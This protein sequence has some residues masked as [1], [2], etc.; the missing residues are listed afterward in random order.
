M[1]HPF[2]ISSV[3]LP[4]VACLL[5]APPPSHFAPLCQAE[6][7]A[8][9]ARHARKVAKK[10]AK[11]PDGTYLRFVFRD[12]SET[13]GTVDALKA[14]TFTLINADTNA[15]E[16]YRYVDVARVKKGRTYVG[17]GSVPRHRSRFLIP[18][19]A[20]IAAAGAAAALVGA[21]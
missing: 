18:V 9:A 4:A 2:R 8:H 5:F 3:V 1:K 12:H 20:G 15:T 14:S 10:L 6:S 13:L 21:P 7:P 11:Y 16:T 19:F 17:E